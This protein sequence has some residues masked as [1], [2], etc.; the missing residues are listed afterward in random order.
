[1]YGLM[2]VCS[3]RMCCRSGILLWIYFE[4]SDWFVSAFDQ[5]E[6]QSAS[7]FGDINSQLQF[8]YFQLFFTSICTV[9]WHFSHIWSFRDIDQ[10]IYLH[11]E[12]HT[13]K[14][15]V[16]ER[17]IAFT[18]LVFIVFGIESGRKNVPFFFHS[19]ALTF[20]TLKNMFCPIGLLIDFAHSHNKSDKS[21]G[22]RNK[23]N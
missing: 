10:S 11:N 17:L 12:Q 1:M 21:D 6:S 19:L 2:L 5:T 8:I 22:I 23:L 13:S 7:R 14:K 18:F 4:D 9:K 20:S 15:F 3:V 16:M